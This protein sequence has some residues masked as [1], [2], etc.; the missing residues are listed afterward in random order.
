MEKMREIVE[1]RILEVYAYNPFSGR[2]S[3]NDGAKCHCFEMVY[4]K[5]LIQG[6]EVDHGCQSL[7]FKIF[8]QPRIDRNQSLQHT[9]RAT[10]RWPILH[11]D[12]PWQSVKRKGK[13][14]PIGVNT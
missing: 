6:T 7:L 9:E 10:L 11:T 14:E 3:T 8:W 2:K 13:P 12:L 4:N 5:V 1:I